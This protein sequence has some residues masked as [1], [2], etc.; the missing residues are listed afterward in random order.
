M[1]IASW[2]LKKLYFYPS[3]FTQNVKKKAKEHRETLFEKKENGER[4]KKE[5]EHI[6]TETKIKAQN[7][8][9]KYD[10]PD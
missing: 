7:A 4:K 2:E 5:R 10:T 3:A 8:R 9:I 6:L 1:N